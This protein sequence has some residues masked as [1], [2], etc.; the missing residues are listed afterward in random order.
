MR[1]LLL[2]LVGLMLIGSA[3]A[4]AV[5]IVP[6]PSP[7]PTARPR[8]TATEAPAATVAPTA[9]RTPR[10]TR[11]PTLTPPPATATSAPT[12]A[13][14]PIPTATALPPTATAA[15]APSLGAGAALRDFAQGCGIQF[16]AAVAVDPL[17]NDARY[18]ETL[19][20]EFSLLT[21]ENAMKF[22]P[23]RPNRETFAFDR[24]NA[25]VAFARQHGMAMRGHTLVWHN[26]LPGWVSGGGWDRAQLLEVMREH[27]ATVVGHYRG[28]VWAWDVVNEAID[29]GGA[30]RDTIWSRTIGPEYVAQAFRWAHEADPNARLF[31]N[32]YGGEGLGAKS[33]AIYA[34]MRDLVGR[35]VP[36]HGV[37]L[38]MHTSVEAPPDPQAVAANMARLADLGLE[39]HITEM[40]VRIQEPVTPEKLEAQ[41]QVYADMLQVCLSASNCT[42]FVLWGFTDCHSWIPN[43]FPGCRAGL[44]FDEN[45]QPKPACSALEDVLSSQ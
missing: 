13:P 6:T 16:G 1:R 19:A 31:Y 10:P 41:A 24:A 21:P 42:A 43:F 11:T 14:T 40:D 20:R 34:L 45:Y 23:L 2:L 39:V 44:I 30:L 18:A 36:I 26:Q 3:C 9:T 33:D 29:D 7:K 37:G 15:P 5:D 28:Q 38:Q 8:A 12:A 27:I 35:G 22:G 4:P 25:L 17:L 32:D